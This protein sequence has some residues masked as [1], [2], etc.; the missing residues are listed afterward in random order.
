MVG[1]PFQPAAVSRRR[2]NMPTT[3]LTRRSRPPEAWEPLQRLARLAQRPLQRF[4]QIEAASGI[5]LIA[6]A[7]IAMAW[8]NSPWRETYAALWHMPLGLRFG[9]FRFERPL[10][11]VVNDGLMVI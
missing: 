2:Q 10:E 5:L 6:A 1:P 9:D 11:W 4:L 8:A 7:T 3:R